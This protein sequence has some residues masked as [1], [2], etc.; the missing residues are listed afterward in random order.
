[1]LDHDFP[2]DASG[3]ALPYGIYDLSANEACVSVGTT[4]DTADFAVD[5]LARW[6]VCHGRQRYPAATE[7][8]VLADSGGSNG[9]RTR[10][11]KHGLQHRLADTYGLSVTVCHYPSGASKYNP[12]EHRV[13][14]EISKNWAGRP[15]TDYETIVNYITPSDQPPRKWEVV[16]ASALTVCH[17]L[18]A[19]RAAR[20]RSGTRFRRLA[21][22]GQP[23]PGPGRGPGRDPASRGWR[24]RLR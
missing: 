1:M 14:S 3:V 13:F 21:P 15:L 6:W 9:T 16:F 2:S 23:R 4:H 18:A 12:I 19:D 11:C 7:L 17:G 20:R 22:F 8:L 5:N 24:S 10:A